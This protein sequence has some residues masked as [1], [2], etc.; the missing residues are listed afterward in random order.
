MKGKIR[1]LARKTFALIVATAMSFPTGIRAAETHVRTYEQS[2]SIMGLREG[3][4][5]EQGI[6]K[7]V[8][9]TQIIETEAYII[10]IKAKLDE[11]L[12]KIKYQL[13]LTKKAPKQGTSNL[14]LTLTPNPN[15]NIKGLK[16]LS[17]KAKI[18]NKVTDIDIKSTETK[19]AIPSLCLESKGYD[20]ISLEFVGD[21]RKAKDARTYDIAIGLDDGD[22]KK[23]F[24]Y[25]LIANKT[26]ENTGDKESE[27]F[28]LAINEKANNLRG[29]IIS[30]DLLSLFQSKDTLEWTDFLV[31]TDKEIKK[32]SYEFNL[33][34]LQETK[35]STID[36]DYYEN[37]KE[38]YSLKK[39]F[40]QA[41]PFA[42][43]IEFDIPAGNI[44]KLSLKTKVDKKN[45]GVKNYSLNNR[46]V[47]NP[48]YLG[49]DKP[50]EATEEESNADFKVNSGRDT[51][52]KQGENPTENSNA[53]KDYNIDTLTND[54][55]DGRLADTQIN[56]KDSSGNDVLVVE[57]NAPSEKE[58]KKEISALS[59]NKDS[60]I[61]RLIAEGR[62]NKEIE[63]VIV[64]L[65]TDL[66][67]YNEEKISDKE[68]KDFIKALAEREKIKKTDLREYTEAILAGLN[69]QKSKAANLN[70][71][72]IIAYAYPVREEIQN[73]NIKVNDKKSYEKSQKEKQVEAKNEDGKASEKAKESEKLTKAF[74]EDLVKLKEDA[75]KEPAKKA[76]VLEGLKN[77]LGL[78]DLAKADNELKEALADKNKSLEEIQNILTSFGQ[79]YKLSKADQAKLMDDNGKAIRKLVEKDRKV[80]FRPLALFAQPVGAS[81]GSLE[82]KKF[83]IRTRFDTSNSDGPIRKGQYF[84]INL[85]PRLMV[86]DGTILPV[87]VNDGSLIANSP[88]YD[89][90]KNTITYKVANSIGENLQ[91]PIELDVDYNVEKIRQLDG[92]SDRHTIKNSISG[93]G[94]R[95]VKLPEVVV[96]NNGEVVDGFTESGG[97]PV[98]EIV[99]P[100]SDYKVFM[101]AH[102]SPVVKDSK[103]VAINWTVKF[104]STKDLLSLGLSSNATIVKGSG[105]NNLQNLK[106]N[107]EEVR[108][109]DPSLS[110]NEIEGQLG[111]FASKNQTLQKSAKE[112]TY[113]FETKV[114]NPQEK[115]LLDLSI[116]LKNRKGKTGA[117][118]LVYDADDAKTYMEDTTSKR[119][120][121][122]NRTTILGE[123]TSN[124]TAKWTVTDQ[125][126]SGDEN[127]GFPLA[128]RNLRGQQ[129]LNSSI[130]AVYG[131]DE[132]TGKMVIK[133]GKTNLNGQI[134]TEESNPNN[135]QA[136]GNIAVYEFDTSI[137]PSAEGYSLAG[138]KI[139]KYQ[140]LMIKQT[141]A[142][143]GEN[144]HM[145]SQTIKVID[146]RGN[147]ISEPIRLDEDYF[148]KSERKVT[149]PA[150][151]TWEIGNDGTERKINPIVVQVLPENQYIGDTLYSY[152][153]KYNY[154]SRQD[155]A[156]NIY[157][158]IE[159]STSEKDAS[160]TIIKTDSKDPTKKLA[161]ARFTLQSPKET[162]S[163][164]T[165]GNGRAS[166]KNI[167]PGTYN[168]VENKAPAGYKLD[169]DTK[170]VIV[171]K[172]GRVSVTGKNISMQGGVI[173][174]AQARHNYYPSYP[175]YMNA[176]H[177]GKIYPN[178]YIEFYIYLKSDGNSQGGGTNKDTRLNLNLSGGG[179]IT[180]VEVV[181]AGPNDRYRVRSLMQ[182]QTADGFTG[183][184]LLNRI[185]SGTDTISGRENVTDS[186]TGKKGYQIKFPK[187]RFSNDWGF[188]VKVTANN[189][190]DTTAVSYD[191]LTDSASVANE[192]KIQ[193]SIGLA[194]AKNDPG[195]DSTKDEVRLN[196]SNEE[197][198]KTPVEITKV[199]ENKDKNGFDVLTGAIFS[200]LDAKGKPIAD[201]KTIPEGKDKGVASFGKLAP[202]KYTIE[203]KKA[204]EKYKK[205]NVIFDV[206][207]SEDGKVTYKARFKE[208][209]GRPINGIDYVLEDTEVGDLTDK[210]EVT[211]VTQQIILQEKQNQPY[212][213]RIGTKE[214]IWEAYGIE[215]YRYVATYTIKKATRGGKFKIQFDPNLDFKRY[216]YE[217]P[218]LKDAG[219]K[220]LAKPYFNYDTNL[221]TYVFEEDVKS[222]VNAN[223]Q[224]VG[225]IP[226]KYYA[227]QSDETNGY[228]FKITVDPDNP[229]VETMGDGSSIVNKQTTKSENNILTV[230]I[231][232][233]YY[234]YDS[235]GGGGPLTSEYI[236]DIYK[237]ADGNTYIK[238]VSYYNPTNMTSGQR[239]LRLDWMSIKRPKPGLEYYRAE[240]LPAFGFDSLNIYKLTGQERYKKQ[241]MPL[242]YG[243]RPE[244]NPTNYSRVYSKSNVNPNQSFSESQGDIRVTYNKGYLKSSEGLLDYGHDRHPLEIQL[245]RVQGNEGYVII[246]TFKVTDEARFKNLWTAYYLSNGQRHTGSYQKG[247]YN[248]AIGTETGKEIP[249]FYTQKIK[250]INKP[251]VPGSFR[252][253]KTSEADKN[254]VLEDAIFELRDNE[255]KAINRSSDSQGIVEFNDIEPGVYILQEIQ[256]PK[257][258]IKSNKRWQVNVYDNGY[259]VINELGVQGA[260]SEYSQ[261][262]GKLITIPVTNKPVGENFKIYKKDGEGQA[263]EGAK[264]TISK[265][266][267]PTFTPR[268]GTSGENGIVEFKELPQGTYIIEE[269]SAPLGYKKL[270]KKW[271]L[272]ID[273]DGKK[274]V[275]NFRDSS[276]GVSR[277]NSIIE[278]PNINWVDVGGRSLDGW[279]LYD[280][281]RADWTG[282]YSIPFKLGTRIVAINKDD[283]YIIQRYVLNPEGKSIEQTTATIHKEKL[284]Y[285]NT[286]W[287]KGNALANTDYQV[288]ELGK[289]VTD[290]IPDIRLAEYKPTNITN[291]V[292]VSLDESHFGQ[293]RMKLDFPATD[294]PLV[295]DIKVPY[296][297]EYAGIGTGMDWTENK[298]T[299]WKSDYYETV[300]IIKETGP[301][302]EQSQGIQGSYIADDSLDVNNEAKTYGFKIKKVKDN[303]ETKV[304]QGAEFKLTGP[305][306]IKE[307]RYMTTG[308]DGMI[309]FD[310][311]KPG[312]YSLVEDKPAPGYEKSNITWQVRITK[313]GKVY[314]K[315]GRPTNPTAQANARASVDPRFI[316]PDPAHVFRQARLFRSA[317]LM[318]SYFPEEMG[319]E[320]G[321]ELVRPALRATNNWE[322]VDPDNST[323]RLN[324]AHKASLM[325]TKITEINRGTKRFKQV[326]LYKEEKA[327]KLRLIEI[328]RQPE[329]DELRLGY[330]GDIET[331]VNVYKVNASTIDQALNSDKTKINATPSQKEAT[332]GKPRRI[333]LEIGAG[334]S[335]YILVEVEAKYT[336]AIGL[337]SD[338]EPD[339]RQQYD[340][341]RQWVAD[342]YSNESTINDKN[343]EK[344]YSL[345]LET[346]DGNG[347]LTVLGNKTIGIKYK[348]RV[349][350]TANPKPGY[351]LAD[352]K[353]NGQSFFQKGNTTYEFDMPNGNTR[354]EARFKE[355]QSIASYSYGYE[356]QN[357]PIREETRD[358]P[359]M[360][361]GT[362]RVVQGKVGKKKIYCKYKFENG[363]L[364]EKSIDTSKGQNGVEIITPMEPKI[365]YRGTRQH[366]KQTYRVNTI[367][368]DNGSVTSKLEAR[369][370]DTVKVNINPDDGYEIDKI[371]VL[372]NKN[373]ALIRYV[374][375]L[376]ETFPMPA[377][378]VAL[379]AYFK[380]KTQA[381]KYSI[382]TS[383]T[384]NVGGSL[385]ASPTSQE[386]GKPVTI[387]VKANS[388]YEI[389]QVTANGSNIARLLDENGQYTF[390]M[391]AKDV[392]LIATFNKKVVVPAQR[393]VIGVDGNPNRRVVV[394]TR[395]AP[396]ESEAGK[397]VE[398][399]VIP[400][401][402][403][404]ISD[405]YVRKLDGSG[406]DVKPL[407]QN[408]NKYSFTMP[409]TN[410][411]I[412]ANVNYVQPPEGTY[413]VGINQEI[414]GGRVTTSPRRPYANGVVRINAIP[415]KGNKLKSLSVTKKYGG[416]VEVK[417]DEKGPY[418][419]MPSSNVT[420]SA[421]F[422]PDG[423][424]VPSDQ[425]IEIPED[426]YAKITNKQTGIELKIYK[427]STSDSP[428]IGAVFE[429]K[430]TNDDYTQD[431]GTFTTVTAESNSDGEVAFKDKNGKPLKLQ[432]GK[433]LLTEKK[434]PAG[435]KKPPAPWR[436]EV[437]EE[438]GQLVIKQSGP[439]HSS[440][441]FLSSK[442]AKAGDNVNSSDPIKYKSVIKSIDP[443]NK[444]FVQRIFIDTRGYKGN[445][446]KINV[447][448][449][450]KHKREEIDRPAVPPV[451]IKEGV[452][453]AYRTTYL[454]KDAPADISA[455]DV[456]NHY[457]LS[458]PN[459]SVINTAR[460]RP[461]DWG[462]DEDQINLKKGGI[463]FIDIEGFYDSSI[464][465]NN[466]TNEVM[467]NGKY[468]FVN[469]SGAEVKDPILKDPGA[470]NNISKEDL[471]K[472]ELNVD[473]YEGAR[474]FY[475]RIYKNGKLDWKKDA[476]IGVDENGNQIKRD[477]AYQ[478][479]ME[480]LYA[481]YK[482]M[483]ASQGEEAAKAWFRGKTDGE[484]YAVWL[485]KGAWISGQ[486]Y[487]AGL[488]Y[489]YID[490]RYGYEVHK[491][492]ASK[493]SVDISSLYSSDNIKDVPQEGM[494]VTNEEEV[495]NITFSKH[496]KQQTDPNKKEDYNKNRLEGAV[497][498]LQK[499]EG[500]FWYDVDESYVASAF[501]GYFGFRRLEPGRYKLIEVTPPEGYKPI[502]GPL[503]EFTIKQIDTRSGKIINPQTKKEV[504]LMNLTIIDPNN[505]KPIALKDAQ[506]K[507]KGDP[508]VYNFKDL[509]DQ[510]KVDLD[511]CLIL[512]TV[513]D[514]YGQPREIPLKGANFIDPDTNK[515]MGQIIA[516]AQ[517]FISLEYKPG[518]YVSEYGSTGG[519]GGALVDYVTAAT[520]KNMG[521]IINEKPGKGK[522]TI[523]KY[524]KDGTT[525]I[526]ATDLLPGAVFEAVRISGK[527][528]E[529]GNILPDA[530]YKGTVGTDGI[531]T[532]KDLPIGNYEL[533]EK[534]APKGYI[535]TGQVWHFTVGGKDLDPYAEDTST[536]GIDLTDK[537]DLV[538]SNIKVIKPQENN[539][540]VDNPTEIRPHVGQS[541][542]INNNFKVKD[543]I[544]IKAGD[545]F[546]LNLSDNIDLFGIRR[547][548][549]LNFDLFADGVGTIAKAKYDKDKGTLTY[550]FTKYADQYDLITFSNTLS[551]HIDLYKVKT[552][553][554][555]KVGIG[556]GK[557]KSKYKDIN[558]KYIV[559]VARENDGYNFI[560]MASKIAM[561]NSETGEFVHYFYINRNRED[562]DLDLTF[563]YTPSEDVKDLM[564]TNY[565]LDDNSGKNLKASMPDSFGVV[566]NSDNLTYNG[567]TQPQDVKANQKV[568]QVIGDFPYDRSMIIKVTGKV[569]KP[570]FTYY[571]GISELYAA[572]PMWPGVL[573]W[574]EI[575]IFKNETTADAKLEISAINPSN[576][577]QFKKVDPHGKEIKPTVDSSGNVTEGAKFSLY[578]NKGS[579]EK[580][581]TEWEAKENPRFVDKDGYI[582]Y[583]KLEEG[584]YKL[585]ED[586]APKGYFKA[587]S[588][589]AYFKVDTSGK[590]Y[591]KVTVPKEEG[592]GTEEIFEEV[593]GTIPINI[594]NNKEEEIEFKKIDPIDKKV[595]EG[596]EF[597]VLYK[598]TKDGKYAGLSLYEDKDKNIYAL[599]KDDPKEGF[600]KLTTN[601][602]VSGKDGKLKFKI[603]APGYYA[604]KESKAP[605]SYIK[606]NGYAKEFAFIDGKIQKEY[607]TEMVVSKKPD[608]YPV[609]SIKAY[610]TKMVYRFNPDHKEL[611]FTKD[612]AKL[613]LSGLP[614]AAETWHSTNPKKGL[615][616]SAYLQ[617]ENGN[618]TGSKTI[619]LANDYSSG[620][621]KAII[622]LYNL[623]SQLENKNEDLG[624]LSKKTLVL[625]M[626]SKLDLGTKLDIKS[627][628]N[629]ENQ[630][631]EARTFHIGT[632]GDKYI[633]HSH[634]FKTY[635]E[636]EKDNQGYKPIE[637]E[638][639]KAVYPFTASV[640]TAIF[641][642]IGL[643]M[644]V[645]GGIY[646]SR[647]KKLGIRISK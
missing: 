20:E 54:K 190:T 37:T 449:T 218:V 629:I 122:N 433:Y 223:I 10:E 421:S 169:Q 547:G 402:D 210:T 125:V 197:F 199:R 639:Y 163:L 634:S 60:L 517:G 248:W 560:N 399:T 292:R 214:G 424:A 113:T 303:D 408:G 645:L 168:L 469:K 526:K 539:A 308:A 222:E 542:Q 80:N 420:V 623:V 234:S 28:S 83:T 343:K 395:T 412:Y 484:K 196:I 270:D 79:K 564:F 332:G 71:D 246:Q 105:L 177:Y 142:G 551:A 82:N 398:F 90:A 646:Y 301:V 321:G 538:T 70:L 427:K 161:D 97:K 48:R 633:T 619:Q 289:P 389:G 33:D 251:Y 50:D 603:H 363:R 571:K 414:K 193:T 353:I 27:A 584:Y 546:V 344:T 272:V 75:K 255:G 503:L 156:F 216:V 65:A 7:P 61:S 121:I 260:S 540:V 144:R 624:I 131:L 597:E 350:V 569:Q 428:L 572:G 512:S 267:D 535:N 635:D 541:F 568:S 305:D 555:Q 474:T 325:E 516:G 390:N 201:A 513:I 636:I 271:V 509:I 132:K 492:Q 226:D 435:F 262:T 453:T 183:T 537:I 524:E 463:Y 505:Q 297:N 98:Y 285:T 563:R 489:P 184:N 481:K 549:K 119:V 397:L 187:S 185:V 641:T 93:L 143:I 377:Q 418:F 487:D 111:I 417:Y 586:Q 497:F 593:D 601:R 577:I 475:Q 525:L 158:I 291:R 99:E 41:I 58:N 162:I 423:S 333:S 200:L 166:F 123:F 573:R 145:P 159:E 176:M 356:I 334:Y 357:I 342:S 279:N 647:K 483:Y 561:F 170:Q 605:K 354:V 443:I 511:T 139:N 330:A 536:G 69:K 419:V 439:K 425:E 566:E 520:A 178:G 149:L 18:E 471:G 151:K 102:G 596:A 77:L 73:K 467:I 25:N 438:D 181:D 137:K 217:I 264:F 243:I 49:E 128:S 388:G 644:M 510:N 335:G 51:N 531:A 2:S 465:D 349:S 211:K 310:K 134:P 341:T 532:I 550:T 309:S 252:I 368:V 372:N 273:D 554:V 311:L 523:K 35:D 294:K 186:F 580:P 220:L 171:S 331:Y 146:D 68:L 306:N 232:P 367:P 323:G 598:E 21:V 16:V 109:G 126:S 445:Y 591:H 345:T 12:E 56:A 266:K 298:T 473:F 429:L 589:V 265:D 286:D 630:V 466:I 612:K 506:A 208:G 110:V 23:V 320:F 87:L 454:I 219:G 339:T 253:L 369:V 175:S 154:Y 426:G 336:D 490:P 364:V 202:G 328:H 112:V 67:D 430:K 130:M 476:D 91:V 22:E 221:L 250:L 508:K 494:T 315:N 488:I 404:E 24:T 410:V 365:T 55:K 307:D 493:T 242:S 32:V 192:A 451:T 482:D 106:L 485:R 329:N 240:G 118:R 501:N 44:A 174:T 627:E 229:A 104:V 324:V 236:T 326:F 59:L 86:K 268:V 30:N 52:V 358:D 191:W 133:Q 518:G 74:D 515:P 548:E 228:R 415:N 614:L 631:K 259:V 314:I 115:Y 478:Q 530:V 413:L 637:I 173:D 611:S 643:V 338:Y 213:G 609:S 387:T 108:K 567:G 241:M 179:K 640:G 95:P 152:K 318:R 403:Y 207:V 288:F 281:R 127:K 136:V 206:Y 88:S 57:K 396:N 276:A 40:T 295:V 575:Y 498:K 62:L 477:A 594:V 313:E 85:D 46:Q 293:K 205:S 376:T 409:N 434:S 452:K 595:L 544:K 78:S 347:Y 42:K 1:I 114:T 235:T 153:E 448:I 585:V 534:Q 299:Y 556:L 103:L 167:S 304:I 378:D 204:P 608:L 247:N 160:F 274:K 570:G 393:Y 147:D 457:D 500:S 53:N 66:D 441:S 8:D 391:E 317:M 135:P 622:D 617:D 468:N 447:Q 225:I 64:D 462:F 562:D 552:S 280:N 362:S 141:W 444:T 383:V 195:Y 557:D 215:S 459:V 599:K 116:L 626:T 346:P 621:G 38:G 269:T 11:T 545:Y 455:D 502:E 394:Y 172:N 486:Y 456:L 231:K 529:K 322:K 129:N 405:V 533:R 84:T 352:I 620:R 319:L 3:S 29:E 290:N 606:I 458:K 625:E 553:G 613:N 642:I 579:A 261:P 4:Q 422:G 117:V 209:K 615:T 277:V 582:S 607:M 100:G 89:K 504:P 94:V 616:I 155:R 337:G 479:G 13:S 31:N 188:L 17:A 224:I 36:V 496:A 558:I 263:L 411:N 351:E 194:T 360:D 300:D 384:N 401:D 628:I 581:G 432:V 227:S 632:E 578:K 436:L 590:I 374:D 491:L 120:G 592:Q 514:D 373:G 164:D 278:K 180:N 296:Y 245:P 361:I 375:L 275:Y 381:K 359:N 14:N 461:F 302:I 450:P 400:D 386:E 212:D 238:A 522:V 43:K 507:I 618:R 150:V 587:K 327:G 480:A 527:K 312:I 63:N 406:Q 588:P 284:E 559:G 470:K 610:E 96:D 182:N 34:K 39:E 440:G 257:N 543:D 254:K 446:D 348:E 370:G 379:K 437:K 576:K 92:N 282:N 638:N 521:K 239:T 198:P 600:T 442:E 19:T 464:I 340:K 244:Q 256:A 237:G 15:S 47:N 519:K 583:E 258:F 407:K 604:L 9:N 499:R 230:N 574:D 472:L 528:D 371:E 148:G 6:P 26:I 602:L 366:Q 495:Y 392:H 316:K 81:P 233:D 249:K 140:P 203:E 416:S 45:T 283:H 385:T 72:E 355:S 382:T 157:N 138:V 124:D 165:D 565:E 5:K 380:V 189:G 431:D 76:G 287:Y 460:W 101:D 107:G